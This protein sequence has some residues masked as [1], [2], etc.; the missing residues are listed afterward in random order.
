M[1][2]ITGS[3][4]RKSPTKPQAESTPTAT[5]LV[6]SHHSC[7]SRSARAATNRGKATIATAEGRKSSARA[8]SAGARVE[9]RSVTTEVVSGKRDVGFGEQPEAGEAEKR[10][11]DVAP[12]IASEASPCPSPGAAADVEHPKGD[13]DGDGSRSRSREHG[14]CDAETCGDEDDAEGETQQRCGQLHRG[15]RFS[16]GASLP[17]AH[18][19]QRSPEP[20]P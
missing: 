11:G 8:I 20:T 15:E 10:R 9:A 16:Y 12:N 17:E 3:R 18:P 6:R 5:T 1:I 2:R 13:R 19:A 4:R 14:A 7:C